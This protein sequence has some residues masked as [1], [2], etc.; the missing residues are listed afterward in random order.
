MPPRAAVAGYIYFEKVK[1]D[2]RSITLVWE[3]QTLT[4]KT[5]SR[6]SIP[7]RRR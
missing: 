7:Y 1:P 2:A 6:L 3:P 5:I 4:G